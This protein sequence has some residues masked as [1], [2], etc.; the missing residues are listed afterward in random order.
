MFSPSTKTKIALILTSLFLIAGCATREDA[1]TFGGTGSRLPPRPNATL[2]EGWKKLEL[3]TYLYSS[4]AEIEVDSSGHFFS[5]WAVCT[6]RSEGV[7]G[8]LTPGDWEI[9][10]RAVNSFVNAERTSQPHCFAY[11]EPNG[12]YGQIAFSD[13]AW[14]HQPNAKDTILQVGDREEICT[15]LADL[16][17]AKEMVGAINRMHRVITLADC[18]TGIGDIRP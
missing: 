14:V 4:V 16:N 6:R 11:T 18:P 2:A 7:F 3:R 15:T 9:V 8:V 1:G 12:R 10:A 17:L 5:D 13:E